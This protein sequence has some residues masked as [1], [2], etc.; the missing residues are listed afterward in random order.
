MS[1]ASTARMAAKAAAAVLFEVAEAG[2]AVAPALALGAALPAVASE[3]EET[4]R[5]VAP[6]SAL[7]VALPAVA[8]EVAE[9][10]QA[11]ASASALAMSLTGVAPAGSSVLLLMLLSCKVWIDALLLDVRCQHC[12]AAAASS[13]RE[14]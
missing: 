9:A 10:G 8:S 4:G 14:L 11:V 5:A 2:Q 6:A 12:C 13:S 3:V 7:A 1:G